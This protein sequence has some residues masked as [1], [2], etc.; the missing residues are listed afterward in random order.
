[1]PSEKRER[2]R[3]GRLARQEE[4]RLAQQKAKR[5]R[6]LIITVVLVVALGG[7]FYLAT[8]GGGGKSVATNSTT[9][10]ST[11]NT[12]AGPPKAQP[13]PAGAKLNSWTCP[14]ADGSS[15]R[16]DQFPS[17]SPPMCIEPAKTY[18]AHLTTSEGNVDIALDTKKTPNTANNYV[19]LSR[20]HYFDGTTIDRID[21]SIDILQT[22]SPKTQDITDPGPGYN[23]KDEGSGFKYAAGDVV[24]ARSSGPDS[25]SSQ[26][27]FVVGPKASALDAQGTYVTFGHVSTGL[28]VLQK[29][30]GLFEACPAGS[31][32]CLGG[33]PSRVVTISTVT[34][35]EA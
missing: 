20:F 15:P 10:S 34:I 9:T 16:T 8:R 3:E 19:V 31:Q 32:S 25:G 4:L 11:A 35:T 27:F 6:Q 29:V 22:G 17:T 13:V 2:Q 28:D 33:A 14:K 7:V 24:M 30:E 21:T 26:Y 18:T 5:R 12:A 23:I 1:M